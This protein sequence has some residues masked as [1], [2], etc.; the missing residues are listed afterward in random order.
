MAE[1]PAGTEGDPISA[2]L[3]EVD[4]SDP[5]SELV[6][7]SG[8]APEDVGQIGM[9]MRALSD[10][11]T[12]EEQLSAA[13]QKYM[14]LSTQD[15]RAIHYLIVAGNREALVTP[16]MLAAHLKISAAST[17]KLLNRLERG[18]H[19]TREVHPTDRRA[20]AI[21]VTPETEVS[22]MQTVGRQQAKRFYAAARLT[23]DEREVVIRFLEDMTGELSLAGSGWAEEAPGEAPGSGR[24][25]ER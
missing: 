10:L 1:T 4:S 11:R 2:N 25:A 24:P 18:G 21:K 9:L 5:R 20:F 16:G 23:R 22:A 7:R 6:D 8:L 17:T 3:Y 19:I 15:M 12:A 14:R 13:S